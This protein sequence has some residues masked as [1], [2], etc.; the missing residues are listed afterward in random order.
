MKH[1]KQYAALMLSF[2]LTATQVVPVSAEVTDQPA[3]AGAVV[4]TA[5]PKVEGEDTQENNKTVSEADRQEEAHEQAHEQAQDPQPSAGAE[6]TEGRES[7]G[8]ATGKE[9]TGDSGAVE[10]GGKEK[11]EADADRT[12]DDRKI[13]VELA[14]GQPLVGKMKDKT[15]SGDTG[16][17]DE[18][19]TGELTITD[20]AAMFRL[21]YASLEGSSASRFL[22]IVLS[23][24]G[25]HTLYRGS[26]SDA[27]VSGA[28]SRIQGYQNA[29]GM[30]E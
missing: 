30:W 11:S 1:S 20:N 28:S 4:E 6:A 12:D 5:L 27:A 9:T 7:E 10:E 3:E 22:R 21:V 17:K 19:R 29:D 13:S 23:G 25:Y 2:A 15:S 18:F 16:K 14:D 26:A 24:E 8:E